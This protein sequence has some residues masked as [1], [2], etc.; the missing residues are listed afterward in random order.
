M[1]EKERK[2]ETKKERKTE[3]KEKQKITRFFSLC[4]VGSMKI[5]FK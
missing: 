3:T 4:V 2:N 1:K 5:G